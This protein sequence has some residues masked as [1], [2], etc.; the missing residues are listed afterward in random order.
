MEQGYIY[1]IKNSKNSKVYIGQTHRNIYERFKDHLACADWYNQGKLK[2]KSLLYSAINK[3]GKNNFYP[4]LLEECTLE[5]LNERE[6]YWIKKYDSTNPKKGYNLTPGGYGNPNAALKCKGKI[7]VINDKEEIKLI[8]LEE[9]PYYETLGFKKGGKKLSEQSKLKLK[10]WH[11]GKKRSKE[12]LE[13]MSLARKKRKNKYVWVHTD[14]KETII[15]KEDLNTYL[16]KGWQLN[17]KKFRKE[18][19][20]HMS[21]PNNNG[22]KEFKWMKKDCINIYVHKS[23]ISEYEKQGYTLG[24][25]LKRKEK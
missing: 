19:C 11:I 2:F 18:I 8:S 9:L 13:K 10:K 25:Y 1:I 5:K 20:S 23:K 3:Y 12:T 14:E 4:E 22:S 24:R 17:R 21:R 15:K 7:K 6:I 16:N